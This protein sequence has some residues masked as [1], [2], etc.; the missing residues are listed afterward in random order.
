MLDYTVEAVAK[1]RKDERQDRAGVIVFG[2]NANI[3]VPPFDDDILVLEG[4]DSY[5][6]LRT[7]AT[8]LEGALKLAKAS[9]PADSSKRIVVVSDGNENLG[10]ARSLAASLADDGIGLDVVP[11]PLESRA[12]VAVEKVAL[13]ADI[14]RGQ[15]ME[16]R[17]VLNNY[18]QRRIPGRLKITRRLFQQEE[19]LSEDEVE[20]EPGKNVYAFS[21][22]IEQPGV[23]TYQADFAP[24]DPLDDLMVQNNRATTFTHVRGR[25]RVLFIEDWQNP[26]EFEHLIDRL[27]EN[28]IEVTVQQS[29]RLFTSLAELQAFDSVILA[30]VPR[31]SGDDAQSVASFSDQQIEMLVRNTE[32][33]GCGILMIGGPNSYG[34]GGWSNTELEKAMPVDFQIR[35]SKIRA[36]GALALMMHAS[37]LADGNHWQKEVAKQA[38]QALG[39]MDYCGLIHWDLG[40]NTWLWRDARGN[41]IARVGSRRNVMLSRLGRMT[42]GDMPE[43]DPAMKMALAAFNQVN[44]SVKLM[45]VISDGDPSRPSGATVAAYKQQG[46]EVTT[47][48]VGTHGPAGHQTLQDLADATGGRYYVVKDARALPKIYVSEVRRV[49]RPLIFE[50]DPPVQ[51]VTYPH[52]ILEGITGPLPPISGFVMTTVKDNPLVE[53]A[54]ISPLP[55][56]PDNASVLAAWTYGLG[57]TAV[58]TTDAGRRW[59]TSWVEWENYDKLFTQLVRWTM[60]PANDEGKFSVSTD[61]RDGKVRL[62][63]TALDKEDEFLNFLTISATAIDPD[64]ESVDVPVRQVAPGRYLGELDASKEGNYFLTINPGPGYGPLMSGVN[65]PYSAE[66]RE[67]ETNRALLESLARLRPSGGEAGRMISGNLESERLDSLLQIDTFRGGLAPAITSRDMWPLLLLVTACV[68]FADVFIRRVTVGFGWLA[69]AVQW[70]R[71]R[72]FRVEQ[73]TQLQ[74]SLDRLRSRKEAIADEIDV[75]RAATRFEP[76][77]DALEQPGQLDE[78]LRE[79]GA[80]DAKPPAG[81]TRTPIAPEQASDDSYTERLL[82]AKRRAWKDRTPPPSD[83]NDNS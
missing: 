16:T 28:N 77:A 42:P 57:R 52:E 12:E 17:V 3:E 61:V 62:V 15:P 24:Q 39:P 72:V 6:A 30:N 50:P 67:R 36:V 70:I 22:T 4:V 76:E 7:D 38:I 14:R 83:A 41:G 54:A 55:N 23:Y 37:E 68:F 44:A 19:L 78:V 58:L 48:A 9:F 43:F 59:A 32:D 33:L 10:D 40:G 60:R 20:L 66:F 79:A 64:L 1:H 34:A 27:R 46:I 2:R 29:N 82:K 75:R 53:V 8:N 26:R 49:A 80:G 56:E 71:S 25:G 51:P 45:I 18:S 47:V 73:E 5:V 21:H 31:S 65:V 81:P 11:I 13:P 69:A 74:Q 35:N 63:I